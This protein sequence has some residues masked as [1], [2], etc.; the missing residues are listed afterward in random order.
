MSKTRRSS[1]WRE[2]AGTSVCLCACKSVSASVGVRLR[3]S[4]SCAS[5]CVCVF[6]CAYQ[7]VFKKLDD[8][9]FGDLP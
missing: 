6:F 5:V 8:I 2:S 9:N 4:V 1:G 7:Q 3:M